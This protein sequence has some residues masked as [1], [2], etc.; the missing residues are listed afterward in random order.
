[1]LYIYILY[2]SFN[3][4]SA[5]KP[6]IISAVLQSAAQYFW[7]TIMG[8]QHFFDS[9]KDGWHLPFSPYWYE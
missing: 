9:E 6:G 7:Y 8:H 1:V 3:L 4:F 2:I 5:I